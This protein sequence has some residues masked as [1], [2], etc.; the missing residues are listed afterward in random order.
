MS[1]PLKWHGGKHYQTKTVLGLMAPH[2]HYVEVFGG[3]LSVLFARDPD[4]PRLWIGPE[5]YHRGVS[6]VVNDIYGELQNFWRVLQCPQ[7]FEVFLRR[8]LA[9]PFSGVEWQEAHR[10]AGGDD[11]DA[12]VRFFI[13]CRQSLAGRMDCFAPLTRRRTRRNMNEQASAWL[14][15]VEG[16]P[17]V[18]E[19]LR[20]VVIECMDAVKLMRREDTPH[21]CFYCDPP[22]LHGTRTDTDVY[23]H[24]YTDDQHIEFLE[25]AVQ[26]KGQVIISGYACELYDSRLSG[27]R[28]VGRELPNNAAGGASKR[29]M[30]EVVWTNR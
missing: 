22:Y 14:S 23:R 30:L 18:H 17:A 15:T 26:C 16:L 6:E 8:I 5:S 27:W 19:R 24:E 4:D 1:S 2:V 25:T 20:R 21:T 11:I 12:A 10:G 7:K 13:D 28:R 29:R 9:T 3:A